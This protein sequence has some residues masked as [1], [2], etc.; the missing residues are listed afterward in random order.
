MRYT[1]PMEDAERADLRIV[2]DAAFDTDLS[3]AA[4]LTGIR[5]RSDLVRH[6][7]RT[8]VLDYNAREKRGAR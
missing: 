7:V 1:V 3:R 4:D 8:L 5:N 2:V 6:A